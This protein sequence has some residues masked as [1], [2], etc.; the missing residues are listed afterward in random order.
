MPSALWPLATVHV[1]VHSLP[2]YQRAEASGNIG[3]VAG[4]FTASLQATTDM[5]SGWGAHVAET[6]KVC[7]LF[8]PISL[9]LNWPYR[10]KTKTIS[11]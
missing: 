11:I 9:C 8:F 7:S 2:A 10:K 4:P 1:A 6:F 5:W 3:A